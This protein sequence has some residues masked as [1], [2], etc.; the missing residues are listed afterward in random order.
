[1]QRP[2]GG[3]RLNEDE[4][5]SEVRDGGGSHSVGGR[6]TPAA[7]AEHLPSSAA[8][9]LV[10]SEI[11]AVAIAVDGTLRFSNAAFCRLFDLRGSVAGTAIADLLDPSDGD[12]VSQILKLQPGQSGW[13]LATGRR[14]SASRFD[15]ELRFSEVEHEGDILLA[16]FAQDV[17]ERSRNSAQLSLLAY[18]DPLTGLANR[19]LYADRLRQAIV[20]CRHTAQCFAVFALDLDGFKPVNDCYGH[21][22]GDVVL[23]RVGQRLLAC[24][25]DSDTVA[26]CG[27]D[28]FAILLPSVRDYSNAI[29]VAQRLV[30]AVRQPISIGQQVL[31]VSASIGIAMFPEHANA[32]DRLLAAADRALY[33]AKQNGRDQYSWASAPSLNDSAPAPFLW[34]AA[35]EV[36]VPE[37]DEQH[38]Q[39]AALFNDLG[40]ILRNGEPHAS[41]LSEILRYTAFHFATEERLMRECGYGGSAIHRDLHRQLLN[42]IRGLKLDGERVSVSLV[43]RFLQEWLVRH[44]DGADRDLAGA[45]LARRAAVGGEA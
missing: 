10:E 12:R 35:H 15:V 33:A 32:V 5:A 45:L 8:T 41:V 9:L 36:G 21:D 42:D 7:I 27:G 37:I 6:P 22:A 20:E 18:S 38:A 3:A 1:M 34:N 23:Q 11:I 14:G 17:T 29:F 13:C 43:L 31:R 44:V 25:R 40:L 19:A 26:R 16:I 39:L 2:R 28:E 30:E 4:N 24:L